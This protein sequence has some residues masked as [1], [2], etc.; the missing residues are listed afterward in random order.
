MIDESNIQILECQT[1][2][3]HLMQ[4]R[5]ILELEET[6]NHLQVCLLYLECFWASSHILLLNMLSIGK[7]C[8]SMTFVPNSALV[9]GVRS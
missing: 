7:C 3:R 1:P 5:P 6:I 4:H 8:N 9:S 2:P